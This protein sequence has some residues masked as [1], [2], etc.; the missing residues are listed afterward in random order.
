MADTNENDRSHAKN[1]G[2]KIQVSGAAAKALNDLDH[3]VGS[4]TQSFPA[5]M[6]WQRQL[7]ARLARLKEEIQ[8]VRMTIALEREHAELT[9]ASAQVHA[10]LVSILTSLGKSRAD[11]TT[12]VAVQLATG[13][14]KQVH[15][16]L[17]RQ[18]DSR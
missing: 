8:L 1:A 2:S 10:S 7:Q 11:A 18:T 3:L 17:S 16:A 14:S 13:L 5:S 4:L 15:D 12:K 6:P 9:T